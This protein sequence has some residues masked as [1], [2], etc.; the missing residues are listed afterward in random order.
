MRG[1][2]KRREAQHLLLAH[3][4]GATTGHD[5][6]LQHH[7]QDPAGL[8]LS[9]SVDIHACTDAGSNYTGVIDFC[10]SVGLANGGAAP[11]LLL[12][13]LLLL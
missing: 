10:R 4:H 11:F 8:P 1:R 3:S 12:L 13:L 5:F 2:V 6:M 7:S 9:P